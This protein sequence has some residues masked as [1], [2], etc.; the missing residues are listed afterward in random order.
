MDL[1]WPKKVRPQE[2]LFHVSTKHGKVHMCSCDRDK[3]AIQA[4]CTSTNLDPDHYY[5]DLLSLC[6]RNLGTHIATHIYVMSTTVIPL[7][8]GLSFRSW[9]PSWPSLPPW[10]TSKA[11]HW[12][13]AGFSDK[14]S[15]TW[16][17]S[18]AKSTVC[19]IFN[20][21]IEIESNYNRGLNFTESFGAH[22]YHH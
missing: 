15:L 14:A 8:K 5:Y 2:W 22:I 19:C 1:G 4:G 6:C 20:T 9:K 12:Q 10:P 11:S 3:L 16:T 18:S 17:Q 21:L 7:Q 13:P